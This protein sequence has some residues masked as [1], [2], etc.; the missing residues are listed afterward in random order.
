MP[1]TPAVTTKNVATVIQTAIQL[2]SALVPGVGALIVGVRTIW[3]AQNP[4][5]TEA[6]WI[7]GL[8]AASNDLTLAADAQLLADGWT[9]ST[10]G[11]WTPPVVK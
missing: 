9:L 4:G 3:L 6:E 5:K 10:E 2:T 8:M 7:G 11:K 1:D